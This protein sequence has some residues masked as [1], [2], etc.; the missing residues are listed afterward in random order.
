MRKFLAC[1]FLISTLTACAGNT[2]VVTNLAPA[3][4]YQTVIP[5]ES[6]IVTSSESPTIIPSLTGIILPT[7]TTFTYT[8]AQD[9]TMSSIAGHFGVTLEA[10][11]AAN[12]GI[13][14]EMLSVGTTLIIPAVS[15]TPAESTPTP[16]PLPVQQARCW[17]ET[18]GGLW[19][20]ALVQNEYAETLENLSAQFT[21]LD[22]N[23]QELASQVAFALLNTLPPGQ[24]MPLA[25]HFP[26]LVQ[27]NGTARVQVL[28]AT[29]LLPGD[30]R[31][32]PVM[33]ENTLVSVDASGRTAQASGLVILTEAGTANTLWVLATAYDAAGNV[34]GV[35]RWE[36]P[37]ALSADAPVSFDF[38]VSSVGPGIDRVEFLAEAR[39]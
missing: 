11:L 23:G 36:S 39:P 15:G 31:Y 38:L 1:L 9:D 34:I 26:P 19:C 20:F 22:S 29:R 25:V 13:Q 14:P 2:E 21:L 30:T 10:L 32:L 12:P 6:P 33:L 5:S 17:P 16:A 3:L 37:S 4:P 18:G 7:P 35:R 28:T 24:S 27:A 8:V